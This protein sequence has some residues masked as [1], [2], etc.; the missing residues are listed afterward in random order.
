MTYELEQHIERLNYFKERFGQQTGNKFDRS[1]VNQYSGFLLDYFSNY[2]DIW[3]DSSFD[4]DSC[5]TSLIIYHS[6]KFF[7]WYSEKYKYEIY[8][9]NPEIYLKKYFHIWFDPF[10]YFSRNPWDSNVGI[11]DYE[12]SEWFWTLDE[13]PNY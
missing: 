6:D 8:R 2:M 3:W 13:Y 1:L 9:Y 7:I 4:F 5:G 10:E 12:F 11:C